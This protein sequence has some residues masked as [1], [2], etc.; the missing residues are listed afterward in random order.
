MNENSILESKRISRNT[1][2]NINFKSTMPTPS[3]GE[4]KKFTLPRC[5]K[6]ILQLPFSLKC[7]FIKF[8]I[9]N[10]SI[11]ESP[12]YKILSFLTIM[13]LLTISNYT[14]QVLSSIKHI[15]EPLPRRNNCTRERSP[16]ELRLNWA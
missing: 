2:E 6:T 14:T 16:P 8:N 13:P 11:S 15:Q 7:N 3:G 4:N 1:Q 9:N 10:L 12:K 5:S